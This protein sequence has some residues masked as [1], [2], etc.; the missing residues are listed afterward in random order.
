MAAALVALLPILIQLRSSTVAELSEHLQTLCKDIDS[1][2][3]ILLLNHIHPEKKHFAWFKLC[4]MYQILF[5]P[6]VCVCVCVCV[7]MYVL[8]VNVCM[9]CVCIYVCMYCVCVCVL[10]V[11]VCIVHTESHSSAALTKRNTLL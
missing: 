11:C 5:K 1:H 3:L 6:F 2:S 9:Y 4:S 7:C 10:C 8:C